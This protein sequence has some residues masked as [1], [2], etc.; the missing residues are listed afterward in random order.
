MDP[1]RLPFSHRA[2]L[3]WKSPAKSTYVPHYFPA[4]FNVLE[5]AS[6]ELCLLP[7]ACARAANKKITFFPL[8]C[9]LN[10][11][12]YSMFVKFIAKVF[13][14]YKYRYEHLL[15]ICL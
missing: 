10:K 2:F 12:S 1:L 6:R 7:A 14:H 8:P 5:R 4:E 11:L 9:E 13:V 3:V 15:L